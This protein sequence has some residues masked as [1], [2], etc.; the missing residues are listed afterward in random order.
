MAFL[1]SEP[2]IPTS[3]L[4]HVLGLG[5]GIVGARRMGFPRQAWWAALAFVAGLMIFSRLFTPAEANVNLAFGP[6][7]GLSLWKVKGAA[8]WAL[9]LIQWAAGLA[10]CQFGWRWVLSK[11]ARGEAGGMG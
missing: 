7:E 10:A 9:L 6:M 5:L 11:A 4:T 3:T 2:F 8:H 1:S